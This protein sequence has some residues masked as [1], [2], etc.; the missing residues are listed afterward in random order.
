[1]DAVSQVLAGRMTADDDTGRMLG[2]SLL[3]HAVLLAAVLLVPASWMGAQRAAPESVMIVSLGGAQGPQ[4]GGRQAESA[5]P[6]QQEAPPPPRPEP[7]RPAA[8]AT[9]EMVVPTKAPPPKAPPKTP[10]KKVETAPRDATARTPPTTG[11]QTQRGEAAANTA[12]RGQGFGGL[13]TGGGGTGTRVD[14]GDFCCPQYLAIMQSRVHSVWESR[15]QSL[16]TAVVKFVV[17]RDGTVSD[18]QLERTSGNSTLDLIARRAVLLTRQL[19]PLPVEYPNP[20]LT[21][22]MTFEYQR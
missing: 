20:S 4:T 6:V 9:P 19:P 2:A 21:V 5:R 22:L 18:V 7:V 17:Q 11:E 16:G 13:S 14:V 1:M 3:G 10:P 8:A 15:Q 12:A